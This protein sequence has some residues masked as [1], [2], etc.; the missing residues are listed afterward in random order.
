MS[1]PSSRTL[2]H[3]LGVARATVTHVCEKLAAEGFL[4][5]QPVFGYG[6]PAPACPE[7]PPARTLPRRAGAARDKWT[8]QRVLLPPPGARHATPAGLRAQGLPYPRMDGW[9]TPF[10]VWPYESV[11]V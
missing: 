11:T 6:D 4:T 8:S 7:S 10:E 1:L 9:Y 3:E 5:T 2:A